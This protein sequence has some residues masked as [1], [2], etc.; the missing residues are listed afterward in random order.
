MTFLKI[1]LLS[2]AIVFVIDYVWIAVLAKNFYINNLGEMLRL[3][4]SGSL[5]PNILAAVL[6]YILIPLGISF[7]IIYGSSFANLWK[8]FFVG[9]L[10]GLIVYGVYDLSNLATL[11]DWP[12]KVVL[13]DMLYGTILCGSVSA[14]VYK[15]IS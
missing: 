9:A 14:I 4:P 7:F 6:V 8:V 2:T 15:I 11:K 1:F 12:I 13:V 10:F 5:S 3:G